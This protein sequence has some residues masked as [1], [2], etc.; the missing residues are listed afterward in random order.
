MLLA[1]MLNGLIGT[2]STSPSSVTSCIML[3]EIGPPYA[4][5]ESDGQM[6]QREPGTARSSRTQQMKSPGAT[7][8]EPVKSIR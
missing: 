5:Y 1:A 7:A 4:G 8:S 3:E 2:P 6:E